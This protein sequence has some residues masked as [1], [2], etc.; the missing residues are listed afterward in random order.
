MLLSLLFNKGTKV[1]ARAIRQ[2]GKKKEIKCIQIGEE[3]LFL[4]ADDMTLY[5]ENT[6]NSTHKKSVR[7]NKWIQQ[8]YRIQN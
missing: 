6:Y 5:V 8:S 2:G 4:V 1:L 3:K 7:T